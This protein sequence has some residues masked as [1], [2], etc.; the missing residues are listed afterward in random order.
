MGDVWASAHIQVAWHN[1]YGSV[2]RTLFYNLLDSGSGTSSQ[3]W[4]LYAIFGI[5]MFA[6]L[7]YKKEFAAAIFGFLAVGISLR[8]DAI[9]IARYIMGNFSVYIALYELLRNRQQAKT[10]VMS[11]SIIVT[12]LMYY[13]WFAGECYFIF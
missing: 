12:G 1:S 11:T 3:Y 13:M 8:T 9:A 2:L 6:Y 10:V 5:T 4:A 7:C